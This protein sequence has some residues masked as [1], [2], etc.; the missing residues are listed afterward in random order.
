[1]GRNPNRN[2]RTVVLHHRM[3]HLG[4]AHCSRMFVVMIFGQFMAELFALPVA[5]VKPKPGV[6]S[7]S[8]AHS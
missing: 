7:L 3:T 4:S 6:F 1:M 5:M 8:S 2:L